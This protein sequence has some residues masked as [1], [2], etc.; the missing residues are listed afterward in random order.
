[1][2]RR[3]PAIDYDEGDLYDDDGFYDEELDGEQ[4]TNTR[5]D[6]VRWSSVEVHQSA[7]TDPRELSTD[8]DASAALNELVNEFRSLLGNCRIPREQIDAVL[9]A[10]DYDVEEAARILETSMVEESSET[11]RALESSKPSAIARMIDADEQDLSGIHVSIPAFAPPGLATSQK[12]AFSTPSPDDI[13][14][15][16]QK[17]GRNRAVVASS[18]NAQIL[19]GKAPVAGPSGL[20]DSGMA[21]A[22]STHDASENL[23]QSAEPSRKGRTGTNKSHVGT[24]AVR[25]ESETVH[26]TRQRDHPSK[27]PSASVLAK[28]APSV[29]IVV[30]GHVDA[31][32]VRILAAHH[33]RIQPHTVTG[34]RF[35]VFCTL[36][37]FVCTL[38]I[39][40]CTWERVLWLVIFCG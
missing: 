3:R 27:L 40:L 38:L 19:Q 25:G 34:I 30:A 24:R 26:H 32:K 8:A 31:G 23:R 39:A 36:L 37:T 9:V 22:N 15:Q 21:S 6:A 4:E 1:M 28:E 17:A 10:A 14:Q 11:A 2:P 33:A 29:A 18:V 7:A 20:T 12:S 35:V 5:S 13:I 16:K